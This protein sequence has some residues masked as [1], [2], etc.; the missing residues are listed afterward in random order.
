MKSKLL[1]TSA[2]AAVGLLAAPAAFATT[3]TINGPSTS[4]QTLGSGS[5]QTGTITDLGTLTVSG[6]TVAVTISGNNA[7]LTNLGVLSQTGTGRAIRDNTGVSGLIINNGSSTNST[8]LIQ[9]A[10]ADVIQMNKSPASLTLNNYGVM[11]SL[12]ASAGGSQV[13]DFNAILSGANIVNNYSTGVIHAYEADAVRPG[14]NGVVNNYG[15][16]ISTTTTGSSSD[17][18]DAQKQEEAAMQIVVNFSARCQAAALTEARMARHAD[19]RCRCQRLFTMSITNQS[20][21]TYPED[22]GSARRHR[23]LQRQRRR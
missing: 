14:V 7:T 8:A 11:T 4:A 12:N 1:Q 18:V 16:I 15:Q 10:D 6:S 9:A 2:I 23:R 20:G 17:G 21:A 22:N 13:V 19:G 5:G 3:F